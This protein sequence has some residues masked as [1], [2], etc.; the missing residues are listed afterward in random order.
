[1]PLVHGV[2]VSH[3]DVVM[4]R[5]ELKE[6]RSGRDEGSTITQMELLSIGL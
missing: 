6:S 1:M 3:G 4:V 2:L 5:I